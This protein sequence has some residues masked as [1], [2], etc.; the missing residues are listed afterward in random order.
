M[1]PGFSLHARWAETLAL[2]RTTVVILLVS[3]ALASR[4]EAQ[5]TTNSPGTNSLR[6]NEFLQMVL[7]HNESIQLRAL[8]VEIAKHRLEGERGAFEPDFVVAA[9]REENKRENTAEQRRSL[10]VNSFDEQNNVYRTGLEGLAPSGAKV[11]LGYTM[12]DLNNNLQDPRLASGTISTNGPKIDEFQTFAGVNV[13]QP[14]LKGFG[15]VNTYANI[16]LAALASDIAFQE[17]RRQLMETVATAEAAYWNLFMMQEQA[18]FFRES[19]GVAQNIVHDNRV[20]AEAGRGSELEILEAEAGLALR[21]TKLAEAEQKR[22]EAEMHVM[23]LYSASAFASHAV[24]EVA[25]EP[26]LDPTTPDFL[27]TAEAAFDLNPDYLAQL[28]KIKQDDIRLAYAKNQKLPQLDLSASY[29]L[30]GL[31]STPSRSHDDIERQSYPSFTVGFEFHVPLAGNIKARNEFAAAR[32]RKE[33]ALLSLKQ[34]ETQIINAVQTAVQKIRSARDSVENNQKVVAF[35]Q[36]LLKT[37]L[38]RLEVGKVES[39]KV[40]EVE[41]ALF[42][43]R[44]AVLDATV[45]YERANLELELV[46]GAILK[47]RQLELTKEELRDRTAPVLQPRKSASVEMP[48][49][50]TPPSITKQLPLQ[51]EP[52]PTQSLDEIEN[53]R[54]SLRQKLDALDAAP[55]KTE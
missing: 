35:H 31:G 17:Y 49:K 5:I 8:E 51:A 18:R 3:I 19:V 21:Q 28:K 15:T 7:E 29:G 16:R 25:D 14:L 44:N 11:R 33:Q 22:K 26:A 27:R 36:N 20:R 47:T 12:R 34:I 50:T 32:L 30:N 13:T 46:Q 54:R 43:S 23:T 52:P 39:Q 42:E 24:V 40:L 37:Q 48:D 55:A 2:A 9:S 45:Q 1:T 6:L 38:E 4:A 53:V 10:R 41:A